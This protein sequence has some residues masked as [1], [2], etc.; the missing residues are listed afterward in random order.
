MP[1]ML[2]MDNPVSKVQYLE[3]VK[4]TIFIKDIIKRFGIKDISYLEKVLAYISDIIGS[5]ISLRN[6]H[7][8]SK[9]FGR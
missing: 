2:K 1:E 3:S 9:Q 5:E 7:N 4:D 6:M 8:A